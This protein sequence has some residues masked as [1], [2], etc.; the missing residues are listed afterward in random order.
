MSV[1]TDSFDGPNEVQ[2]HSI[3]RARKE[4][5]CSACHEPIRRGDLYS[6]SFFVFEGDTSTVK[7]CAR[8]ET[9]YREVSARLDRYSV[10]EERLNC[11]HTWQE[12]FGEDPPPEIA[13]LAFVTPAEAQG[14]LL[15]KMTEE[16][17]E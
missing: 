11:G 17:R 3:V 4:H 13:A 1:D 8:C 7:R 2:R 14:R 9:I 15:A 5:K 10:P 16:K 6:Y 12:N